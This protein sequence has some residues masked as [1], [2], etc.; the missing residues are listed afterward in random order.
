MTSAHRSESVTSRMWVSISTPASAA[1]L[2][3]TSAFSCER[4]VP[5]DRNP[6]FATSTTVANPMPEFAPVVRTVLASMPTTLPAGREKLS[7]PLDQMRRRAGSAE[8]RS[9]DVVQQLGID[10]LQIGH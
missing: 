7:G 4:T 9:G 3:T 2:A 1:A 10:E 6:R 5:T 8:E